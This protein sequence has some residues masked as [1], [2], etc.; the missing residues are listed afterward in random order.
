MSGVHLM[1]LDFQHPQQ[2]SDQGPRPLKFCPIC[3]F[4]YLWGTPLA[5]AWNAANG[6]SNENIH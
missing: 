6:V 4:V 3:S 5:E 1:V 2:K